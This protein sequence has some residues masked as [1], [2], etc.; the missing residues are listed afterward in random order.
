MKHISLITAALALAACTHD[1]TDA[2]GPAADAAAPLPTT[3][4]V[5][6]IDADAQKAAADVNAENADAKLDELER[7]LADEEDG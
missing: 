5:Q 4:E 2:G 7:A 6:A 1:R 3:E